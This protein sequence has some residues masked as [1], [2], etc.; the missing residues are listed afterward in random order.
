[1]LIDAAV[2]AVKQWRYEPG[3]ESVVAVEVKFVLNQ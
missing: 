1:M 2:S 3:T